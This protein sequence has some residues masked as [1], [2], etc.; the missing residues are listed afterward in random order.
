MIENNSERT[1]LSNDDISL[2]IPLEVIKEW[3]NRLNSYE[4]YLNIKIYVKDD[5]EEFIKNYKYD[6]D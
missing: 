5:M 6:K 4:Y 3:I 2:T 1:I